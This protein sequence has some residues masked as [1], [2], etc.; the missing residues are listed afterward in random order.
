MI[1]FSETIDFFTNFVVFFSNVDMVNKIV[2]YLVVSLVLITVFEKV[3]NKL[4]SLFS[5]P[6]EDVTHV[7]LVFVIKHL[8]GQ[9]LLILK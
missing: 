6:I 9:L 5:S 4:I 8:F 2:M 3:C 7:T 1:L